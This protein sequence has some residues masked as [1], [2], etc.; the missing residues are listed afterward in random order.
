MFRKLSKDP[1]YVGGGT[2]HHD[3]M[4]SIVIEMKSAVEIDEIEVW[5]PHRGLAWLL[6]LV[7]NVS[8]AI[9]IG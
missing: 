7:F 5:N 2:Q 8:F 6:L 1:S 3:D 9:S 4:A